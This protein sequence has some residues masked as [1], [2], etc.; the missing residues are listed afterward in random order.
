METG[1]DGNVTF[2]A[3]GLGR[4]PDGDSDLT[5]TATNLT[6]G[7]TS[8]FIGRNGIPATVSLTPPSTPP[9]YGGPATFTASVSPV[10][11]GLATPTGS[12]DF[13]DTTT[14]IDLGTVALSGGS[15]TLIASGLRVGTHVITATYDGDG[16]YLASSASLTQT[17]NPDPSDHDGHPV[18]STHHP[19]VR[20]L[21]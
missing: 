7:D 9:V 20:R 21:R 8:G 2:L 5:A 18:R 15:A 11:S 16:N 4:L 17:V 14:G 3:T 10:V 6:T 12:V 13:V 1:A 19:S